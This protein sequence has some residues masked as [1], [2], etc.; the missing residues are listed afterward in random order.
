MF[1]ENSQ[2]ATANQRQTTVTGSRSRQTR[3][4]KKLFMPILAVVV[5]SL[6]IFSGYLISGGKKNNSGS[7]LD[8]G[9]IDVASITVGAEFGGKDE[10]IY[11]DQAI[12][13]IESG[14]I[15]G[16]G[17]HKLLRE[18]GPSQ[19]VYLTSS[20][21]N[22]DLMVGRKVQVWGETFNTKKAGWFMD[23]GRLKVLE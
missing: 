22:L 18:G 10:S 2:T 5:I 3:G 15:D 1:E 19:T 4:S 8:L 13:V 7:E 16:E 14:G 20:A 11:K 6:G 21:L 23:V 12:G 9:N 17:T